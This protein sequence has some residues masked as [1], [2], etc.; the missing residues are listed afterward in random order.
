MKHA[1]FREISDASVAPPAPRESSSG[2]GYLARLIDALDA[3]RRLQAARVI[4]QSR[5]LMDQARERDA[6]NRTCARS[7]ADEAPQIVIETANHPRKPGTMKSVNSRLLL[8]IVAGFVI[9]HAIAV[10]ALRHSPAQAAQPT[11]DSMPL[12]NRD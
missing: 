1:Q 11:E 8:A 10:G 9:L 2:R 5:H 12:A 7:V 6:G 4:R 3:S